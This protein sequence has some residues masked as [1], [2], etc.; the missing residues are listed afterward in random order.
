MKIAVCDDELM[1]LEEIITCLEDF[2]IERKVNIE[3][4]AF[5]SYEPL[6]ERIDEFDVFIMDYK[7][8]IIDGLTFAKLIREKYSD[9]KTIIFITAYDD[10]VYDAFTVKTHRY[11][12]KPLDRIKLF[13]ALDSYISEKSE[14]SF[15][16]KSDGISDV[17]NISDILYIE[18]NDK[19]CRI[20]TE[21]GQIISRK[22]ISCFENQLSGSGFFRVHRAYLVNL[23]KIRSYEK[24]K[25]L[26]VNGE[27]I[28]MSVR[29]YQDFCREYIRLK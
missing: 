5:E 3:Y 20:C 9:S 6:S 2:A 25:I 28:D 26:L 17:I 21:T 15:V 8:P 1:A 29:R 27:K 14:K 12:L 7:T 23:R 13:E 24:S 11:L 16:L 18:V 10:I 22:P 19:E 4:E